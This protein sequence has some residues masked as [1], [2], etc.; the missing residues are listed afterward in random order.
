MRKTNEELDELISQQ[1]EKISDD[2]EKVDVRRGHVTK[3]S[4]Q[5]V[6]NRREA[7]R[8]LESQKEITTVK[9][10]SGV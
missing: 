2:A 4:G 8:T 1:E 6:K 9:L 3:A 10:R 5:L 7:I